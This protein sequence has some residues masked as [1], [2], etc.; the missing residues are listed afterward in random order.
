VYLFV[1]GY[2]IA[3]ISGQQLV[4]KRLFS[5]VLPLDSQKNTIKSGISISVIV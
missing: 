2:D 4:V 1:Y 3:A 5:A